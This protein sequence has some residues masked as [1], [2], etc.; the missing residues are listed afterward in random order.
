MDKDC[1]PKNNCQQ[2]LDTETGRALWNELH[3]MGILVRSVKPT[4][5]FDPPRLSEK[6]TGMLKN[7]LDAPPASYSLPDLGLDLGGNQTLM[8]K[9][10]P[11]RPD[12]GNVSPERPERSLV[13]RLKNGIIYY[14]VSF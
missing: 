6:P 3:S 4:L 7:T 8:F 12:G 1:E 13:D 9:L 5:S 10:G 2:S 11:G 14:K